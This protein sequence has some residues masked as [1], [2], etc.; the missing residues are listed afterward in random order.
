MNCEKCKIVRNYFISRS[1]DHLET[2]KPLKK[3][4]DGMG[5][6]KPFLNW[7]LWKQIVKDSSQC[8]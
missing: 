7:S 4:I 3:V 5:L 8:K 2:K 6:E 1:T